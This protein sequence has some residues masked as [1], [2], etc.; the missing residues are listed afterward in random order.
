MAKKIK[1]KTEFGFSILEVI[2][3][4]FIISMGLIGV[5]SLV[6]QN[7]QVQYINK[8]NLIAS[9]L[10]QEGI[11]L[12]RNIRDNNWL[13]GENWKQGIVGDGSYA[14]DYT[15]AIINV[16][17]AV[18]LK[19]DSSGYYWHGGGADTNFSRLI[20]A[21]ENEDGVDIKSTVVWEERGNSHNYI[22]ETLLYDWK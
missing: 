20:E 18:V 6:V 17:S 1:S 5:L 7:V 14:I 11:E 21:V 3:A 2:I 13:D 9:Q 4:I 16:D 10:A 12:V 15:G 19:I 22:A 8:N